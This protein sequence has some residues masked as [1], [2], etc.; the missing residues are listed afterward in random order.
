ML[1]LNI[2]LPDTSYPIIIE[3][4]I[5]KKI[6]KKILPY[7]QRKKIVI[8]TDKNVDA[9][10][11][12]ALIQNI[13]KSG[14]QVHLIRLYPGE[15]SKSLGV[16]ECVYKELLNFD[17]TKSD[18]LIA[19][20]GGVIG[21]L[22]G[23]AAATFL[24]GIPFIQIPTSLIAQVDSS[25]GGKTAVNLKEGKNLV[26]SFYH[27]RAVFIDPQLLHSLKPRFFSDGMAEV[28]KYGCIKDSEL[29]SKLETL[30]QK[31]LISHMDEIILRCCEIKKR[32]VEEDEKDESTRMLLNF[33]HTFGHA[34][35][36]IYHYKKYTHGEAVAV[37]MYHITGKSEEMGYTQKGTAERIKNLLIKFN[38]PF[39][40]PDIDEAS[41]SE[42]LSPDKKSRGNDIHLV[43]LKAI[44]ESFIHLADKKNL[45]EFII[46]E[47]V[48]V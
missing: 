4:D 10:Y 32:I 37:G 23:F 2:D 18:L 7:A 39:N 20:G 35:E 30:N 5:I 43:L 40:L 41:L 26:G 8:V 15:N 13:E 38:L 29:F 21:D 19:F 11:G 28:I 45:K 14:F 47:G 44:G 16:L 27:P 31:Q 1:S 42:A 36:K 22:T 24:R 34:V 9:L 6:G 33:G 48:K 25:I 17:M 46:K 3:K 12:D